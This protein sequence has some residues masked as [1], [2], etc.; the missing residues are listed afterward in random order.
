MTGFK[1]KLGKL[2]NKIPSCKLENLF[3]DTLF[4]FKESCSDLTCLKLFVTNKLIGA[5]N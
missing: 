3:K 5:L 4:Q 2:K 1:A